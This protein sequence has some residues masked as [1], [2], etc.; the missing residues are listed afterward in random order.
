MTIKNKHFVIMI[1]TM[2]AC[3][4]TTG[5][6]VRAEIP[7]PIR[8]GVAN[9]LLSLRRCYKM[10]RLLKIMMQNGWMAWENLFHLV[11][12]FRSSHIIQFGICTMMIKKYKGE[13]IICENLTEIQEGSGSCVTVGQTWRHYRLPDC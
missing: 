10:K 5:V 8:I 4:I 6:C 7:P 1:C 3:A 13:T 11:S 9:P 2:L 12:R